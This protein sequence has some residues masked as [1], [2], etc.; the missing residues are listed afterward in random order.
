[1]IT[2]RAVLLGLAVALSACVTAQMHT[3]AQL[4]DIARGCGLS[5]GEVVQD[6]EEKRLLFLYRVAPKPE[7][8]H[9]VYQWARRNHLTLVVINAVNDGPP[10]PD[11]EAP[12]S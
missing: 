5:Y 1:M 12:K 7:Q 10:P 6:A 2:R 11:P 3:E 9:C 4:D 8:R